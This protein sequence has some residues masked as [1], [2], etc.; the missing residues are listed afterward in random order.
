MWCRLDSLTFAWSELAVF[1]LVAGPTL[2]FVKV[3]KRRSAATSTSRA[4]GTSLTVVCRTSDSTVAFTTGYN[5]QQ[6]NKTGMQQQTS[7]TNYIHLTIE[8]KK[9]KHQCAINTCHIIIITRSNNI[10]RLCLH[11]D[12]NKFTIVD[13]P[14]CSRSLSIH[15]CS[16]PRFIPLARSSELY[17]TA[18]QPNN[19]NELPMNL[20]VLRTWMITYHMRTGC[21]RIWV[22]R[23]SSIWSFDIWMWHT[24]RH[25]TRDCI[26]ICSCNEIKYSRLH[27]VR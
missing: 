18:S 19:C 3:S 25:Y 20:F 13:H 26:C 21:S 17:I 8:N 12:M 14:Q 11:G 9:H 23:D 2:A 7:N 6:R 4:T 27:Y 15:V 1:A 16:L 5:N 24:C 22:D 10:V